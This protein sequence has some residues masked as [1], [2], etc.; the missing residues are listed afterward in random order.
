M[1]AKRVAL[2]LRVG[3]EEMELMAS[4]G[5]TAEGFTD[6]RWSLFLSTYMQ[7]N[8]I[9]ALAYYPHQWMAPMLKRVAGKIRELLK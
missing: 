3:D 7:V 4:E 2:V 1:T 5:E 8:G 9:P 6:E